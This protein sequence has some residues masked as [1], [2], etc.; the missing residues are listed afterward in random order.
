MGG[1]FEGWPEQAFDVLLRLDG[2][3]SLAVREGCRKDRERLVR[4][5]MVALLQDL[6]DADPAYDDFS[7]WH[8]RTMI[9][10]WQH[11]GTAI[12]IA[13]HV[14]IGVGFDLDGLHVQGAWWYADRV[15]I[16]RFR[17]AVADEESGSALVEILEGIRG[18]GFEIA[19]DM[20]KRTPRG[21]PADHPRGELLRHRSVLARRPLGCD[22]WL[23]TPKAVGRVLQACHDLR[24]MTDWFTEHVV[25]DAGV[26]VTTGSSG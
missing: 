14:E 8:Y 19:G 12:R 3:P 25:V 22:D 2:D 16:D 24:P 18:K 9:R 7:V 15:P 23:H 11:Q 4:Q 5:P 6:A 26:G 1:R 20:M 10:A 17:A 13:R 21:Y